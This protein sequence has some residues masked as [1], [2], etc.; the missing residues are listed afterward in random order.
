[1][2]ENRYIISQT[3][4]FF[5]KKRSD[6]A[7]RLLKKEEELEEDQ[8]YSTLKYHLRDLKIRRQRALFNNENAEGI[9]KEI[10]SAEA[11]LTKIRAAF[12]KNYPEEIPDCPICGDKGKTDG[13]NCVC[14]Y[15]KMNEIAYEYL[16][17]KNVARRAFSDDTLSDKVGS[18]SVYGAIKRFVDKLPNT[19]KNVLI[20]GKKGTGKTFL[21]ECAVNA[22]NEKKLNALMLSAYNLNNIFVKSLSLSYEEKVTVSDILSSCD[23][24]AIDDLGTESIYNKVTIENLTAIISD[25][26]LNGKPF[27]INTNLEL[28]EIGERY[29]ERLYSRLCGKKT[30]ILRMDGDDLRF[31]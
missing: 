5:D 21:T 6:K 9:E 25:R 28:S 8:R 23:L 13:G 29:G 10:A 3:N 24:L 26:L 22:V 19:E 15:K 11:E 4:A 7:F 1:M 16:G 31:L 2:I 27:M 30:A 18:K 17:A 12:S 14:Y 20:I